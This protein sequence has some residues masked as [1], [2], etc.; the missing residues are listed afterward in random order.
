MSAK[1]RM[2]LLLFFRSSSSHSKSSPHPT[3]SPNDDAVEGEG[4][5][6]RL[7]RCTGKFVGRDRRR[8]D[9][10]A[11]ASAAMLFRAGAHAETALRYCSAAWSP[12]LARGVRTIVSSKCS[13][14]AAGSAQRPVCVG[15][16]WII[17]LRGA[18]SQWKR[19]RGGSFPI[20][21]LS[22]PPAQIAANA[23]R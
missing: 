5:I 8:D 10:S 1:A 20:G 14:A 3:L 16:V 7:Q 15:E 13:I 21:P 12:R 2:L 4:I 22:I 18:V 11:A 6:Q 17:V 23:A 9:S 19:S